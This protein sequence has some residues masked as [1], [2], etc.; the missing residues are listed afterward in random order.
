M[1]LLNVPQKGREEKEWENGNAVRCICCLQHLSGWAELLQ[2]ALKSPV[3]LVTLTSGVLLHPSTW[4]SEKTS[5]VLRWQLPLL[6]PDLVTVI[7]SC[8]SAYFFMPFLPA[9]VPGK[10]WG[11][12]LPHD[13]CFQLCLHNTSSWKQICYGEL[14]SAPQLMAVW[15]ICCKC[16]TCKRWLVVSWMP[17]EIQIFLGRSS[18]ATLYQ[19]PVWFSDGLCD[20]GT[21]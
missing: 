15:G 17:L 1:L 20:I 14:S 8:S 13:P 10:K 2:S 6:L 19:W 5:Q 18:F 12:A 3:P 21:Y 4:E 16:S 9:M 11:I 7:I